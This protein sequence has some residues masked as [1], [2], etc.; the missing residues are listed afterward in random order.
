MNNTI[1]LKNKRILIT[2]G[3]KGIGAGIVEAMAACG[4]DICINVPEIDPE[5]VA[6]QTYISRQYLVK[7]LLLQADISKQEEVKAMFDSLEKNW[8]GLDVLVNNAGVES[9]ADCLELSLEEWDRIFSVN[10]RG[11]FMVAQYAGRLMKKQQQGCIINIS[12]IHDKVA[13]KG[14]VHYCASK[15]GLNMLSKCMALELA[16]FGVRV[17]TISPGAIETAMNRE[18]IKKIGEALFQKWIPLGRLGNVVDVARCCAFVASDAASYLTGTEI[19]LDGGYK[20]NTIQY[21]PRN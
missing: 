20:E 15:A 17:M 4:G 11:A 18:E 6:F 16:E 1:D 2:G 12:S 3:G 21:D 7:V 9:V 13:R 5:A 10:L 8:S 14:L 19:Y